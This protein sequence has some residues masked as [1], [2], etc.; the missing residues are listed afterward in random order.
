M[1]LLSNFQIDK[2]E[3][4]QRIAKANIL[5]GTP[6][7]FAQQQQENPT[8]DMS[9]LRILV[10][11]EADRLLDPTFQHDLLVITDNLNLDR[12]CLLFSATLSKLVNCQFFYQSYFFKHFLISELECFLAISYRTKCGSLSPTL[13]PFQ[14][15]VL[16]DTIVDLWGVLDPQNVYNPP[17]AKFPRISDSFVSNYT[18]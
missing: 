7:R 15:W 3:E 12:Q 9:N 18:N 17:V 11:D 14:L 4:W 13:S 6:G 2:R 16:L 10:L 8:L 5:I 1:R